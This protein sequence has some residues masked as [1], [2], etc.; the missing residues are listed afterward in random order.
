[1]ITVR[2]FLRNG[3]VLPDFKCKEFEMGRSTITGR[4]ERYNAKGIQG[5]KPLYIDPNE[6]VAA[7][8]MR[9]EPEEGTC[10][11]NN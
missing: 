7:Y 5:T 9:N 11:E 2:I 4:I 10:C 6:I 1:M 3:A 8:T